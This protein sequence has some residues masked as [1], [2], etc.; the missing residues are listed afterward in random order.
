MGPV[1]IKHSP[2]TKIPQGFK[3]HDFR[4]AL[5]T[6]PGQGLGAQAGM[7]LKSWE[8][9]LYRG[10]RLS[11]RATSSTWEVWGKRSTGWTLRSLNPEWMRYPASRAKVAGLQE[12]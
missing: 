8:G 9:A 12:T 7:G 6:Y 3:I 11:R 5:E 4:I 1:A 10:C 2:E